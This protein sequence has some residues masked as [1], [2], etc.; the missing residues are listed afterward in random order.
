MR[1]DRRTTAALLIA[2]GAAVAAPAGPVVAAGYWPVAVV[3]VVLGA[4]LVLQGLRTVRV[5]NEGGA[6]GTS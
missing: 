6:G 3:L 2:A 1:F 5:Q 4:F